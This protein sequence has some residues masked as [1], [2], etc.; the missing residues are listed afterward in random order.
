MLWNSPK[1]GKKK[2]FCEVK[3][4][5]FLEEVGYVLLVKYSLT[6]DVEQ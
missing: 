5:K 1:K 4:R 6:V 3:G 2:S